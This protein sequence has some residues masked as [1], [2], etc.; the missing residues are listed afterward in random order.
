MNGIDC[1]YTFKDIFNRIVNRIFTGF[2]CKA[3]VSHILQ[4]DYFT[5]NL[6]LSELFPCNMLVL[7][8]IRTVNTAVHT[9]I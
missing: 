9:V 8:V 7:I 2:D 1:I 5:L 6:F 4:G 3:L